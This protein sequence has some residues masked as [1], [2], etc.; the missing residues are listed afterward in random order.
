MKDSITVYSLP[1]C[2]KCKMLKL[3]MSKRGVNFT[4]CEDEELMLKL[5]YTHPPIMVVSND[6]GDRV[7]GFKDAVDYI[8][9]NY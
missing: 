8:K 2:P 1:T 5:G 6:S 4:D 7:M 9:E 3:E